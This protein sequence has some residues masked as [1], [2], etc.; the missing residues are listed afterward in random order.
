MK[1]NP[2][3]EKES[4]HLKLWK[5]S[6]SGQGHSKVKSPEINIILECFRKRI[7]GNSVTEVTS[8]KW[9][10]WLNKMR[11]KK[12]CG[13]NFCEALQIRPWK[14]CVCLTKCK[15]IPCI[16]TFYWRHFHMVWQTMLL[17]INQGATIGSAIQYLLMGKVSAILQE[18]ITEWESLANSHAS[19]PRNVLTLFP[20]PWRTTVIPWELS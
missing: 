14:K 8:S 18:A 4:R 20:N 12:G 6:I 2:T 11:I 7:I 13:V 1:Y 19:P 3:G 10:S 15:K 17:W 16:S 5:Q 9:V